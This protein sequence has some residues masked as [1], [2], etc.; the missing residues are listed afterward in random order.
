MLHMK[1]WVHLIQTR[2]QYNCQTTDL[3]PQIT[4]ILPVFVTAYL[5]CEGILKH[6]DILQGDTKHIW[7]NTPVY[8]EMLPWS[9][10]NLKGD[11]LWEAISVLICSEVFFRASKLFPAQ[12][13]RLSFLVWSPRQPMWSFLPENG[14]Q[15]VTKHQQGPQKN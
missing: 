3:W 10:Q 15:C 14:E 8:M 11:Y 7:R 9:K 13:G 1:P 2:H 5:L 4:L 12:R 6:R